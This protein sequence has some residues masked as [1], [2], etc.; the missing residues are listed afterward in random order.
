MKMASLAGISEAGNETWLP[1]ESDIVCQIKLN[2]YSL[3]HFHILHTHPVAR[4]N[5]NLRAA[6][7]RTQAILFL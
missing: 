5:F 7:F 1:L 2:C 3:F 4:D 6:A